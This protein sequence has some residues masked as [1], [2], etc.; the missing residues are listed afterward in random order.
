M[1]GGLRASAADPPGDQPPVGTGTVSGL[2]VRVANRWL[3]GV[4]RR[5][6][7]RSGLIAV[8]R[9]TYPVP[10]PV[11]HYRGDRQPVRIGS[12]TSI[13]SGVE[14][15]PGGGHRVEWVTTF[16]LR[17]KFGLPGALEDGHP[18]GRGPIVIGSDVWL[19]RNSLVLSGVTIG[20]GAVV[21]AGAVVTADVPPY[22]IAGG[23]PARVLRYRFSEEQIAALLRIRWWEWPDEIVTE[24]VGDLSSD[25]VDTFIRRYDP[26]P[27]ASPPLS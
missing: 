23:I 14:I 8:G 22:A 10:P 25:D 21:A 4:A 17:L 15:V 26:D 27:P 19:G 12:F 20:D 5:L 11:V 16:P 1:T 7:M 18:V 9:H 6:A 24:R 13:A 2:L 3:P